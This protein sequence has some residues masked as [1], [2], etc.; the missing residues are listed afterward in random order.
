MMLFFTLY[1]FRSFHLKS[2]FLRAFSPACLYLVAR[3]TLCVEAMGGTHSCQPRPRTLRSAAKT[4]L[5]G[6]PA[7]WCQLIQADLGN[8]RATSSVGLPT[9]ES[10]KEKKSTL[11]S[12][13]TRCRHTEVIS[14]R[15]VAHSATHISFLR[16]RRLKVPGQFL[17]SVVASVRRTAGRLGRTE[18]DL[19]KSSTPGGAGCLPCTIIYYNFG[20]DGAKRGGRGR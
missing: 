3:S 18:A 1:W 6:T 19:M 16:L 14:T 5:S 7:C 11:T 15:H 20:E 4:A 10:M 12:N 9:A 2:R 13:S 17:L 8:L